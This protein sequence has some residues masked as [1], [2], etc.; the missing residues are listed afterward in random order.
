MQ[1]EATDRAD[2]AAGAPFF[3]CPVRGAKGKRYFSVAV[4]LTAPKVRP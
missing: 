2:D 4:T 3:S 1:S